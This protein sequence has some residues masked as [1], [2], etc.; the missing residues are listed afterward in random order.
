MM[1]FVIADL[2]VN[3]ADCLYFLERG[4]YTV[5]RKHNGEMTCVQTF[6]NT[7]MWHANLA[8]YYIYLPD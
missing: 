1:M 4:Y 6:K 8:N 2:T 5:D 7:T 3:I